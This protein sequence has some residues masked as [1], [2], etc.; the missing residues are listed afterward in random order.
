[1]IRQTDIPT[2]EGC[3]VGLFVE[4]GGICLLLDQAWRAYTGDW[5]LTQ[6]LADCDMQTI[7]HLDMATLT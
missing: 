5:A 6:M 4:P 2:A 7:M 1:M 3:N